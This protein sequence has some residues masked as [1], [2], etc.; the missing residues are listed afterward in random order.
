MINCWYAEINH[1]W[2]EQELTDKLILLPEKLQEQA[3]R[4]RQWIDQ[5]LTI[6]GKLLL[7]HV[8]KQFKSQLSLSD[9]N[10]NAHHRPY[11]N[12]G[13]DFNIAHSG[14]IVVCCATDSGK[15][16]VDIEQVKEIDLADYA[17]YFTLKEWDK[18]KQ[19]S[20]LYDGFYNYWTR[21]EAVLKAIGTGFH[22]P[23]SSV[24][25]SGESLVYDDIDYHIKPIVIHQEYKCHIATT[26]IT[27]DV[28]LV[29]V[30]L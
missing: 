3:L 29:P 23:L 26:L 4:K 27:T 18:I 2:S 28:Q 17:D 8:L 16:G 21:K 15:I 24:D 12:E 13:P 30:N 6:G 10:Y 9:L 20:N 25:V 5:Q 22:T 19:H 14:N 1:R 7:L 11:F